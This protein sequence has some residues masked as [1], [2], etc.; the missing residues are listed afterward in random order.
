MVVSSSVVAYAGRRID[1]PDSSAPRF[2]SENIARVQRELAAFLDARAA[3]VLVG[4]AACGADILILEEARARGI[5]T[6]IVLPFAAARFRETSV[7]D[8]GLAWG[9]RYDAALAYAAQHGRVIVL[10]QAA[11]GDNDAYARA[12]EAIFA[13]AQQL[14]RERGA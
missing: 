12:T 14:A 9:A 7:V 6:H 13:E 8:R 3:A 1:A 2:P 5:H 10:P 4:S 11:G